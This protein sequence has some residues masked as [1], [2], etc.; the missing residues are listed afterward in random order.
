VPQAKVIYQDM[1]VED[2]YIED[3]NYVFILNLPMVYGRAY[4]NV[5]VGACDARYITQFETVTAG[6]DPAK[7]LDRYGA[8]AV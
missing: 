1:K 2:G 5:R 8:L 3:L 6:G 7:C 4:T